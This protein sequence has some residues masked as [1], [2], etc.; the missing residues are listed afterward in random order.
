MKKLIILIMLL[1]S[2]TTTHADWIYYDT[3]PMVGYDL[4][5]NCNYDCGWGIMI[6]A[7]E[8]GWV[9][10]IKVC[11]SSNEP[12]EAAYAIY[13]C[14]NGSP[15]I[16]DLRFGISGV[17][18]DPLWNAF[19]IDTSM[20]YF[21]KDDTFF[22]FYVQSGIDSLAACFSSDTSMDYPLYMWELDH[23]I[24]GYS[25]LVGDHSQRVRFVEAT[26]IEEWTSHERSNFQLLN[27]I[28]RNKLYI[29]H[30]MPLY[31]Y[32]ADG[33]FIKR[34]FAFNKGIYD[35]SDLKAGT[36]FIKSEKSIAKFIKIH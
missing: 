33:R 3:D 17:T 14:L 12:K 31:M 18:V 8:D 23:G 4:W 9:D 21:S 2:V 35:V 29:K 16:D 10:S 28:V 34:L 32:G 25:N 26:G 24:F 20:T 27:T 22:F 30:D 13:G 6:I 7:P 5:L 1:I 19:A 11:F 36:Y 15:N